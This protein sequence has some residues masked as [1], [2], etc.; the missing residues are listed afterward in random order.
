MRNHLRTLLAA[1]AISA[2]AG[3]AYAAASYHFA[4]ATVQSNGDLTVSFKE[5]GLGNTGFSSVNEVVNA[6]D[7]VNCQCVNSGGNCPKA[8]NKSSTSGAV[9]G[10]G[11]FPVRN[12]QTTGTIT[13]HPSACGPTSPSCSP[14]QMLEITSITYTGITIEDVTVNDGPI[15]TTPATAA[16]TIASVCQ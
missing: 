10:T 1:V 14:P 4:D 15:A 11:N 13:V 2:I 5:T 6:T 3:V 8:A 7:T 12:G 16:A 9:T